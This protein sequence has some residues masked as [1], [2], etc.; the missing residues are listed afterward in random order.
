M[1][2]FIDDQVQGE[3]TPDWLRCAP[4]HIDVAL[5]MSCDFIEPG[6]IEG[7]VVDLSAIPQFRANV[8]RGDVTFRFSD[9]FFEP[10]LLS[11]ACLPGSTRRPFWGERAA[12]VFFGS[13]DRQFR[14]RA[15]LRPRSGFASAPRPEMALGFQPTGPSVGGRWAGLASVQRAPTAGNR[16]RWCQA[17]GLPG[18]SRS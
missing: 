9:H 5:A 3:R 10:I 2:T 13:F 14:E 1:L 11:F 15:L 4:R 8:S 6:Q 12:R 7:G 18:C 17:T 16:C